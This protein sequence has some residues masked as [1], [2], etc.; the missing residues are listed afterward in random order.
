MN[1]YAVKKKFRNHL[2]SGEVETSAIGDMAFLLLV[3]FIVTSSFMMKQGVFL[4]LPSPSGGAVKVEE[5]QL[6]QIR[7]LEEGYAI[8]GGAPLVVDEN[9]AIELL[10]DKKAIA[11]DV[12][13]VVS[14]TPKIRYERL[15]DA[16]SIARLVG[17]SKISLKKVASESK[18]G[19]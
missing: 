18:G 2:K 10:R 11:G 13:Y 15:I 3:F 8:E 4:S 19:V 7:P 9:R 14:M 1:P 5:S 17:V 12:I 6:F 16:L